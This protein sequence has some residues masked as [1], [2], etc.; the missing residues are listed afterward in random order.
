G[1][2]ALG[3]VGCGGG[4]N[5]SDSPVST[6]PPGA[7]DAPIV[8]Q[9]TFNN[10]DGFNV[11]R[12]PGLR[13]P[14]EDEAA[15]I[16]EAD[17]AAG[18]PEAVL[19]VPDEVDP[20]TNQAPYFVGLENIEVIAGQVLEVIFEPR[21][22]DG[23][24][25]GM[26]PEKL[27]QGGTFPDNLDGTKTF[28]W[29]PLQNDVGFLRFTATALD[30][31]NPAYRS[32][33]SILIKIVLPADPSTIPNV[34]PML[35]EVIPH[36]A[37]VN[38]PVVFEIKGIDLNGTV[39]TLEVRNLPAGG[40]FLRH[41][42]FEEVYVLKFVPDTIGEFSIDIRAIDSVDS[43]L[44]STE[45]LTLTVLSE[46][47]F[48]RAG[49]SLRVLA[50]NRNIHI[51]F[52][53]LQSFY[54]RPDGAIY[55]VTAARE[56]NI[57]TPEN[58][59]KMD[60][61]NPEPGRYQFAATDNLIAF[62]KVH[63]M[64][65]HG[66]PLV[67]YRQLPTWVRNSNVADREIHMTDYISRV[68]GRYAQDVSVWDVVNEPMADDGTLRDS[69]WLESMGAEYI[70]KALTQARSLSA[71]GTLLI[72][73]FDIGFSGPKFNGLMSLVDDLQAREVPL[74]G[75]GFQ[76][77]LFSSFDQFAELQLNFAEVAAR[78]ID[79]YITEL[80]VSLSEGAT[81][82]RQAE[83]YAQIVDICL[84]QVRCK[85]IQTWGLT[86]QYSFR[87][88]FDPLLFDRAYQAKPAYDAVFE[89]LTISGN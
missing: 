64:I 22:D 84:E 67:W 3:M 15:D 81:T 47:A 18:L 87:S 35:D 63:N 14:I 5:N 32:S 48:E 54:H 36:T 10:A 11:V 33:Q 8:E 4:S 73:E 65:V 68:M 39:P 12:E 44:T 58:S 17:F 89:A 88:V 86:D 26:F 80:D 27:P 52:A 42:R 24:L 55:A 70:D 38:D 49:E 19:Q 82:A 75:I 21:D 37:R 51:G 85:A 23:G 6:E 76:L 30:P 79:I 60:Y 78:N 57:V 9:A 56:Y 2:L 28:R 45:A 61:L 59:M 69:V 41:P 72:N 25:P 16:T 43:A 77:H 62:A 66:H 20:T 83:V 71:G 50:E 7:D 29:Q 74:D 13:L 53:A 1:L 46:D 34:A 31:A 40:S